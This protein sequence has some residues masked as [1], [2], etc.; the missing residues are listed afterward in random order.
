MLTRRDFIKFLGVVGATT[1]T[2]LRGLGR[3]AYSKIA[4]ADDPVGELYAGF[5]LLPEGAPIPDFVEPGRAIALHSP[6][7]NLGEVI[8]FDNVEGL[9]DH[10]LFPL[11]IPSELPVGFDFA[12]ADMTRFQKSDAIWNATLSFR[13]PSLDH[14]EQIAHISLVALLEYPR[15]FP[16]WPVHD[17]RVSGEVIVNPEKVNLPTRTPAIMLPSSRGHILQWIEDGVHY[18][19]VAEHNVHRESAIAIA[20]SLT[21]A[22]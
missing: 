3:G 9:M 18:M 13:N 7:E 6:G 15:P 21:R 5:V 14:N 10:V 20:K 11:Y 17:P 8:K 2:P 19:L 22:N 16:V 1:L 4:P 12:S